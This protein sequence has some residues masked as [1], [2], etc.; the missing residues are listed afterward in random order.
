[1]IARR[2]HR[3]RELATDKSAR[4]AYQWDMTPRLAIAVLLASLL[5]PAT[6]AGAGKP[7]VTPR[8]RAAITAVIDRYVQ[9]AVERKDLKRAYELSGPQ[10]RG[11]MSLRE[12]L[13]G[14]IPVYP[15]PARDRHHP[16]WLVTWRDGNDVGL[17]L[18]VQAVPKT[19]LGA[20][21]F[22]IQMTKVQGRWLVNAFLPQATFSDPRDGAKVFSEQDLLPGFA[23]AVGT[24][25]RLSPVWFAVPGG[26]AV[27]VLV[28]LP[29][30]YLVYA[31]RRDRRAYRE[32]LRLSDG[33]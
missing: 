23:S 26:L 6:A 18:L 24:M 2:E 12:W 21:A 22:N 10:V 28:V 20:I 9:A 5:L 1:L 30:G 3:R 15:F 32:Y 27:L 14:G 19:R 25:A 8:E 16:G 17:S 13:H 4:R 33:T 31:R 11:G 7:K 29:L